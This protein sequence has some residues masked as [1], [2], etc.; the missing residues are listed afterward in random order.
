MECLIAAES[1]AAARAAPAAPGSAGSAACWCAP[2]RERQN[3]N[4]PD[5]WRDSAR[6]SLHKPRA[7]RDAADRTKRASLAPRRG[8][9]RRAQH[10]KVLSQPRRHGIP[11]MQCAAELVDEH[12]G[13]AAATREF[14]MQAYAVGVNEARS[15]WH[16]HLHYKP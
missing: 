7:R 6:D 14:V 10:A 11:R 3:R 8:S 12:N 4:R 13:V 16:M 2:K 9:R 15:G 1:L 5:R